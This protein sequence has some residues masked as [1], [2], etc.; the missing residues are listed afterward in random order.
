MKKVSPLLLL[1][2][3]LQ[4]LVVIAQENPFMPSQ[5]GQPPDF[6]QP[7]QELVQEQIYL[8][9]RIERAIASADPNVIGGVRSQLFFHTSSVDRL[10]RRY[11]S[12]P[13]ALCRSVS[14][15]TQ[16]NPPP[17]SYLTPEQL[18]LYCYLYI[19]TN[20]LES[21]KPI[22]ERRLIALGDVTAISTPL[23]SSFPSPEPPLIG[24]IAKQPIADSAPLRA[25]AIVISIQATTPILNT[26]R[27]L[28][29]ARQ[30]FPPET[31]FT[32]PEQLSSF[33]DPYNINPAEYQLY[34]QFITLPNTGVTRILN[35]EFYREDTKEIR[36]RLL[37]SKAERF[38]F[39][40]LLEEEESGFAPRLEIQIA[41]DN[42]QIVQR[43]LN[44]GFMEDLGDVPIENL[45]PTLTSVIE[46]KRQTFLKYQPPKNL[47]ELQIDR[48]LFI[49]GKSKNP[50]CAELFAQAPAVLNHTYL[51]RT[52]QF[53]LPRIVVN[54]ESVSR[55]QRRNLESLLATPSSDLLIA[56]RPVY[57]R[58]DG[59]YTVVW[60]ILKQF[61]NPEI[62]GL[63][64]Y[65]ELE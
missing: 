38:P 64:N 41:D 2:S 16:N 58:P 19:S 18:Q 10:L 43:E 59:T 26:R 33:N 51:V 5:I 7:A 30:L 62:K 15:G 11:Y 3:L 55:K 35:A 56:F 25:P 65:V 6:W 14:A 8:V 28:A 60:R 23:P 36:N 24:R 34:S 17:F 61:P 21:V 20:T 12:S 46:P 31:K 42:F 40:P 45:D 13:N 37:G 39:P 47:E 44:Y 54:D 63:E 32:L 9:S 53:Q 52:I 50:C 49:T 1:F 27:L 22:L 29:Q 4:P 57:R 48:R